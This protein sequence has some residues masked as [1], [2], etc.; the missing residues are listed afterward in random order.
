[1][2]EKVFRF[3]DELGPKSVLHIY[4]PKIDLKAILVVDNVAAGPSIGGVRLAPDVSLEE[5]FRLAR[6]MTLKNAAAG[7]AHG[8]GKAVI[9]GNPAMGDAEKEQVIRAFASAIGDVLDF[10][11]GPDMGTNERAMA[12]V[13]DETGRSVGLPSELGGIP[14]DEIG[15]TGF[16]LAIATEIAAPEAGLELDGARIAVQGFGSVGR[17]AARR[18]VE[19]GATLVA[20]ADSRGTVADPAGLDLETLIELKA[21]GRHVI[22]LGAGHELAR[23]AIVGVDC[24]ILIPAARPDAVNAGN[25]ALVK[26]RMIIQGANI[27]V[28]ED[29][30]NLLRERG[31]VCPP[32]FISNAGG[33]ICAAVEYHGGTESQAFAAIEDKIRTNMT[34][35]LTRAREAGCSYRDAAVVMATERVRAAM[36]TRRWA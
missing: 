10:I 35:V 19:R 23:E 27:G 15:A 32:D 26:A 36:R 33:V 20:V 8:G 4:D 18:L 14:L 25:V 7:L 22:E 2:T 5:C 30:E 28:T 12:W 16:G 29:A 17:H 1:M 24:D 3:C 11:P 13:K 21:E 6:A 9:F 34:E 31:V